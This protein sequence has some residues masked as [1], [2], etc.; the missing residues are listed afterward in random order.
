MLLPDCNQLKIVSFI[1]CKNDRFFTSKKE[2]NHENHSK[3]L[4][5]NGKVNFEFEFKQPV[6]KTQYMDDN[7]E[8]H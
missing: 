7:R 4:L 2:G 6:S 5:K 3:S 8:R 1:L